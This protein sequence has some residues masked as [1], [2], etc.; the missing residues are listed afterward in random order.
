MERR[1]CLLCSGEAIFIGK[2]TGRLNDR[3]YNLHLKEDRI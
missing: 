2:M 3:D 1:I